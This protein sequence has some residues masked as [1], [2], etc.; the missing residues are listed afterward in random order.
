LDYN[1][2]DWVTCRWEQRTGEGRYYIVLLQQDLWGQW[3]LTRI[4]GG[5][6]R[7][8]G[9]AKHILLNSREEGIL[10]L[11]KI[12]ERRALHH[13]AISKIVGDSSAFV[14]YLRK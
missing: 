4:W 10:E 14:E 1:S 9:Q 3:I 7:K 12:A 6:Q 11:K 5:R 8:A 13:Y 2:D